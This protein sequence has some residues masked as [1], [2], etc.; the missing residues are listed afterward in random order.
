MSAKYW[1]AQYVADVFRNEPRNVGV[2]VSTKD[3]VAAKFVGESDE[4]PMDGRRLRAFA[5][6]AVYRQWVE[7]WR[8]EVKNKQLESLPE[9]SAVNFRVTEGGTVEDTGSDSADAVAAYLFSTLVSNGGLEEALQSAESMAE[10]KA[11]LYEEIASVLT[12][13]RLLGVENA[14]AP[15][16]HPVLKE[17]AVTGRLLAEYKPS[18]SQ[19][20]GAL[21]VMETVDFTGNRRK[22]S[23]DHAAWAAYMFQ[24]VRSAPRQM[25]VNPLAIIKVTEEDKT[26]EDVRTGLA[27]LQNESAV[28]NWLR[29]DEREQFLED[30]RRVA[31]DTHSSSSPAA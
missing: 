26:S 19:Q 23:R 21:Y 2:F 10:H 31:F 1:I 15:V 4:N 11:N 18:F 29:T 8:D 28:V 9:S 14:A 25:Q 12:Q 7:F 27:L 22:T 30:R 17:Q 20:N 13:M 3:G 16:P 6:P 24:D 5:H